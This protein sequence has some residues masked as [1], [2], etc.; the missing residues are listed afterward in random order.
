MLSARDIERLKQLQEAL[1]ASEDRAAG[2]EQRLQDCRTEAGRLRER[3][4]FVERDLDRRRALK[5]TFVFHH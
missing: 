5:T 4:S 1:R 3:L 2:L